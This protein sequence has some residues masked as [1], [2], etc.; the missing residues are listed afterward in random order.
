MLTIVYITQ[1][2]MPMQAQTTGATNMNANPT[3]IPTMRRAR[4][5][6]ATIHAN[7]F[8]MNSIKAGAG[9]EPATFGL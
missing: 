8:L 6:T 1:I 9:L 3:T 2:K 5:A 4:S 7:T